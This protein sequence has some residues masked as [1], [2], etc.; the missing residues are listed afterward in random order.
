MPTKTALKLQKIFQQVDLRSEEAL[1]NLLKS[2]HTSL[3]P[4]H[5][6]VVIIKRYIQVIIMMV[7][8]QADKDS[9]CLVGVINPWI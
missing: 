5:Y 8:N 3:P 4:S 6:L 2:F 9:H 1:R 7:L